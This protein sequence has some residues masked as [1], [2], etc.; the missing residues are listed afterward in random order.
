[1][2]KVNSEEIRIRIPSEIKKILVRLAIEKG[3]T[4][5]NVVLLLINQLVSRQ[6]DLQSSLNT[7][8]DLVGLERNI[9]PQYLKLISTYSLMKTE[10]VESVESKDENKL[11]NK[12]DSFIVEADHFVKHF[13]GTKKGSIID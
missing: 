13:L 7:S 4:L 5:N 6:P 10:H 3:T 11:K 8:I 2:K 12:I 9:Y 1:M